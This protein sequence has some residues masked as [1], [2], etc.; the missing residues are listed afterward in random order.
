MPGFNQNPKGLM[1]NGCP[2]GVINYSVGF[3]FLSLF[4]G[5]NKRIFFFGLTHAL[6]IAAAPIATPVLRRQSSRPKTAIP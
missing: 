6:M 3:R 5:E 2:R 4:A 1:N